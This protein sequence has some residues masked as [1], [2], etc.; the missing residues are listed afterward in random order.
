MKYI[1]ALLAI[2]LTSNLWLCQETELKSTKAKA[3]V[4]DYES[5][6]EDVDEDFEKQLKDL[7]KQNRFNDKLVR[8]STKPNVRNPETFGSTLAATI[9]LTG[10]QL[11]LL[12]TTFRK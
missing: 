6:I 12:V 1:I 5:K 3:A 8:N 9:L 7:E 2:F 4:R 10:W 11:K